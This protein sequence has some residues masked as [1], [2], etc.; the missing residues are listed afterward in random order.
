M[1][2]AHPT[3]DAQH[4]LLKLDGSWAYVKLREEK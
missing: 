2:E 4:C 3:R 1:V